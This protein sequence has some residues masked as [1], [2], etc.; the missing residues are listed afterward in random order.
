MCVLLFFFNI[1][2]F[3]LGGPGK[4]LHCPSVCADFPASLL[5]RRQPRASFVHFHRTLFAAAPMDGAKCW[6]AREETK[7][8]ISLPMAQIQ[9]QLLGQVGQSLNI[10]NNYSYISSGTG[11]AVVPLDPLLV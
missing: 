8:K 6:R 11:N 2:F 1:S 9:I 5:I 10:I 4:Y 7:I 3:F